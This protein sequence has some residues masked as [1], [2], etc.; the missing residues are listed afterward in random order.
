MATPK[1]GLMDLASVVLDLIG[2]VLSNPIVVTGLM[3][4]GAA[5][6]AGWLL[7]TVWAFHDMAYR[8]DHILARYLAA[9]W[10]LISGPVLLPLS[11]PILGLVRPL[12]TPSD[13]RLKDLINAL[14]AKEE[15]ATTCPD[16]G[17]RL[18]TRWV[19]C[20]SC[21]TWLV[22]M[23]QRCER[24][25]PADAEICPWCTWSPGESVEPPA[26]PVPARPP[27]PVSRPIPV[28]DAG[29]IG[30][31]ASALAAPVVLAAEPASRSA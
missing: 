5:V 14:R 31:P 9:A 18:D 15:E 30:V 21:A 20:P 23:C 1:I 2:Q 8:S 4:M 7:A 24:W 3:V 27:E 19:R 11:L 17:A 25:A 16:C 6:V 13:G 22:R 10:V 29:P 28:G 26:V 12:E